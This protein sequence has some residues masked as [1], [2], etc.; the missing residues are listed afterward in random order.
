MVPEE[1][2]RRGDMRLPHGTFMPPLRGFS[3]RGVGVP[4][5]NAPGYIMP[6][7]PGLKTPGLCLIGV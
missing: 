5:A 4:G 2:P 6:P 1:E 3:E 7:L